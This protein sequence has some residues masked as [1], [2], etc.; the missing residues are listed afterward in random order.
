M[1]RMAAIAALA[2]LAGC[3]GANENSLDA[4]IDRAEVVYICAD[5]TAIGRDPV[6]GQL[7][8]NQSGAFMTRRGRLPRGTRPLDFCR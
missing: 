8:F 4:Q 1:T 6:T 5:G 3:G 7:V 2:L